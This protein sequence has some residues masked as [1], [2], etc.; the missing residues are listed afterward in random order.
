MPHTPPPPT[1]ACLCR[2]VR[3]PSSQLKKTSGVDGFQGFLAES[4]MREPLE[5]ASA[6]VASLNVKC[7]DERVSVAMAADLA[8]RRCSSLPSVWEAS[9]D[10]PVAYSHLLFS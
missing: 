2:T 6:L 1:P 5:E 7:A 8:A 3:V 4:E 9:A 10:R